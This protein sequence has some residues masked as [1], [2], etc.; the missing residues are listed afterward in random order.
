MAD[1]HGVASVDAMSDRPLIG[2]TGW[3]PFSIVLDVPEDANDIAFGLILRGTGRVAASRIALDV[4][5]TSVA[6]TGVKP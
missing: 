4:V 1:P 5:D 2:T 3:K 6:T